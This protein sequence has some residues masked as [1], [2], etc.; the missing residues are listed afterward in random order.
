M[1]A[2]WVQD[3]FQRNVGWGGRAASLAPLR[4]RRGE[5][6][7]FA[8]RSGPFL[9]PSPVAALAA[10]DRKSPRPAVGPL[11]AMT[12]IGRGRA[13]K[14]PLWVSGLVALVAVTPSCERAGGPV[15]PPL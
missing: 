8:R 9:G 6:H 10:A 13:L 2:G 7:T 1:L 12:S 3:R 4:V 15:A 14:R 11:P 5:G